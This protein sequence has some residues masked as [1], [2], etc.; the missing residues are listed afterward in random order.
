MHSSARCR[1]VRWQVLQNVTSP[2]PLGGCSTTATFTHGGSPHHS[3]PT[4]T[5]LRSDLRHCS[6]T[7]SPAVHNARSPTWDSDGRDYD[8]RRP[9]SRNSTCTCNVDAGT[10]MYNA[11][12]R[13]I[14][15]S[16]ATWGILHTHGQHHL[17]DTCRSR[18]PTVLALVRDRV[19]SYCAASWLHVQWGH[20]R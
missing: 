13:D 17:P 4:A 14:G 20:R 9:R 6:H 12:H 15:R 11:P 16:R 5:R 19:H 3:L 2:P 10:Y 18:T 8:G 7:R 1:H